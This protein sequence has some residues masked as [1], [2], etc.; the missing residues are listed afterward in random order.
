LQEEDAMKIV[1]GELGKIE[2]H[3]L[4]MS[5]IVP[6]PI[7]FVSTVGENGIFNLAPYSSFSSAGVKP[8]FVSFHVGLK[9]DG[10][11][12]D[13]LRNIQFSKDFVIN[14]VTENLAEQM[15]RTAAEYSPDVD[16]FKEAGLT[17]I[18]SDLVKAPRVA[19]SPVSMECRLFEILELPPSPDAGHV[20]I[21]QVVLVH[22][23]DDLWTG[24]DVDITRLRSVG[25]LGGQ[26]YCRVNDIFEMKRP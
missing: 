20:I 11:Q 14:V 2:A 25:R 9:R 6:R 23:S 16:E 4:M 24:N 19:E 13:T 26:L 7:A 10:R 1:P 8:A 15:N 18:P 5:A 17:A 21:G 12:K 22:V 3:E